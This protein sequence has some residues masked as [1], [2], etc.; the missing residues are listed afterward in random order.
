M[1]IHDNLI[2]KYDSYNVV[3]EDIRMNGEETNIFS[4][5]SNNKTILKGTFTLIGSYQNDK[6][7][8]KWADSSLLLDK[9]E[10]DKTAKVRN[11]FSKIKKISRAAKEISDIS[12]KDITKFA[13]NDINILPSILLKE[14]I[15]IICNKESKDYLSAKFKN[16]KTV[17]LLI[18]TV[19][20]EHH[21]D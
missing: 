5:V 7:I 21:A 11:N 3:F 12:E 16:K 15:D 18:D 4:V 6:N 9:K 20:Y 1:S 17:Y 14:Y 13:R 19:I 8:W 10:K 2:D